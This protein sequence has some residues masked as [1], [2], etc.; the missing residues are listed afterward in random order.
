MKTSSASIFHAPVVRPCW[1]AAA[2]AAAAAAVAAAGAGAAGPAAAAVA[3]ALPAFVPE[4]PEKEEAERKITRKQNWP[5]SVP[6]KPGRNLKSSAPTYLTARCLWQVKLVR[7]TQ[8]RKNATRREE[9]ERAKKSN[10]IVG[11]QT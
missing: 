9:S 5:A 7:A 11:S 8:V 3:A 4:V 2:A 1:A 10:A 6:L